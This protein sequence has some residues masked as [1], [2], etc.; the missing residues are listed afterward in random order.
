M[1]DFESSLIEK[2][3]TI[4][5]LENEIEKIKHFKITN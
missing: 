3:L 5:K 2:G 1:K 4:T